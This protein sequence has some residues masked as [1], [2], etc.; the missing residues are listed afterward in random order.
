MIETIIFDCC[1]SGS[2]T[3]AVE[4]DAIRVARGVNLADN[5]PADLDGKIWCSSQHDQDVEDAHG[6]LR[7]GL[8]S[9]IFL[10]ACTGHE[11]A[12]EDGK[13]LQGE[14]TQAFLETIRAVGAD[15]ITYARLIQR[16]P[17]L[18]Q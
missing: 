9:H 13:M 11:K 14:F 3:R 17:Q 4:G 16:I 8:S 15:K 2:G 6:F 5:V 1:Y 18:P 12:W 7:K 10:A